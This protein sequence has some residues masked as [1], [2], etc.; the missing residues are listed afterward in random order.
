MFWRKKLNCKNYHNQELYFSKVASVRN[1]NAYFRKSTPD[2]NPDKPMPDNHCWKRDCDKYIVFRATLPPASEA[3][4][5]PIKCGC[6]R[7]VYETSR[8]KIYIVPIS[9]VVE[10]KRTHVKN[11]AS[12]QYAYDF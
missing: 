12:E 9:A 11:I 8:C 4:L 5:Q 1:I 2:I 7:S 3:T 6:S 10:Q